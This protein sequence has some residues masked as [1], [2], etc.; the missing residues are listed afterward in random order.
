MCERV[1]ETKSSRKRVDYK[2]VVFCSVNRP[3]RLHGK[4]K[5]YKITERDEKG[6]ISMV[7]VES[8]F[9]NSV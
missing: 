9:K 3:R 8:E 4:V 1:Q 7:F 5:L 2:Q 6:I